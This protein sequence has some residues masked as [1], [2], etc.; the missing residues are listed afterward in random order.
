MVSKKTAVNIPFSRKYYRSHNNV[1]CTEGLA[2]YMATRLPYM[3]INCKLIETI[4]SA[5]LVNALG[6]YRID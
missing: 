5:Q 3:I 1:P 4:Q 2:H 6:T